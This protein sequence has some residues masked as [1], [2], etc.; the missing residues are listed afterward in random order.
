V[1]LHRYGLYERFPK[2]NPLWSFSA[3][4]VVLGLPIYAFPAAYDVVAVAVAVPLIVCVAAR[5]EEHGNAV[6]V[7]RFLGEGS[8]PIYLIHQPI[9]RVSAIVYQLSGMPAAGKTWAL[10]AVVLACVGLSFLVS[11]CLDLPI[12]AWL[13][14]WLPK[15]LRGLRDKS[16]MFVRLHLL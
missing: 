11:R 10:L 9:I 5:G 6:I 3:L 7:S 16:A 2:L 13:S 15:W 8:Y 14:G 4:A 12:R 1:A